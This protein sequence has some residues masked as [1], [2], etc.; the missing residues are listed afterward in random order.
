MA[1]VH[2]SRYGCAF[3]LATLSSPSWCDGEAKDAPA[4]V[5]AEAVAAEVTEASSDEPGPERYAGYAA[6]LARLKLFLLKGKMAIMSKAAVTGAVGKA[7]A[8]A[9]DGARYVA[10]SSD[11]G[12]SMR[13][14]LKPW[15]V[16]ATYGVAVSYVAYDCGCAVR[17]KQL[18]GHPND[19]LFAT[20]AK[21]FVFH[22]AVSLAMPA[23]VIHTA[24]HQSHNVFER[25][26]FATFPRIQRFGPTVI[27]LGIIPF[28]PLV[29]PP[30]E[31][32]IDWVF[33]KFWPAWRV[34]EEPHHKAH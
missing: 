24:V 16:H 15:M 9:V 14:V 29:D 21:H 28:L 30:A 22:A 17:K 13:P 33:D 12:E 18:Q 11:V 8:L 26:T 32:A 34:G 10:Y 19:T 4:A 1:L 31:Y 25:P 5:V 2:L 20:G 27:G 3:G 23:L 7:Q 6:S